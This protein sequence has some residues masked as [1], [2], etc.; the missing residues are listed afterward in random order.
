MTK[1]LGVEATSYP[2]G[3][4]IRDGLGEAHHFQL[5]KRL[6]PI[7]AI[8]AAQ[9]QVDGGSLYR[10]EEVPEWLN[11]SFTAKWPLDWK[12]ESKH[13]D[14]KIPLLAVDGNSFTWEEIGKML[15]HYEESQLK[16]EMLDPYEDV[17]WDNAW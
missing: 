12:G 7:G 11:V 10:R 16:L 5:R 13:E 6:E 8:M 15:M 2:E 14:R 9:E 4:T 1:E 3:V 17:D